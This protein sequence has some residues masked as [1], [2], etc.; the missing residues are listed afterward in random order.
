MLSSLL[1]SEANV[2]APISCRKQISISCGSTLS[3]DKSHRVK[4]S[5]EFGIS[6]ICISRIN[7][8]TVLSSSESRTIRQS[9][10]FSNSRNTSIMAGCWG[11]GLYGLDF[12]FTP[13]PCV[14]GGAAG[15][16]GSAIVHVYRN[17][18]ITE[19]ES[20]QRVFA[21][22]EYFPQM[23]SANMPVKTSVGNAIT[24]YEFRAGLGERVIGIIVDKYYLHAYEELHRFMSAGFV[25]DS[26]KLVDLQKNYANP[27]LAPLAQQ[28]SVMAD[29]VVK[30]I[31][32]SLIKRNENRQFEGFDYI[33][34]ENEV[35]F[36]LRVIE[37]CRNRF[38]FV[39]GISTLNPT[40]AFTLENLATCRDDMT[41]RTHDPPPIDPVF[42]LS[43]TLLYDSNSTRVNFLR[44]Y[45]N[46]CMDGN[47]CLN[48]TN[49]TV[50]E[51]NI[52]RALRDPNIL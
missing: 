7:N 23:Y 49:L 18:A 19:E 16:E 6:L 42:K 14:V 4:Y 31:D 17:G 52:L 29:I 36:S 10:F 38:A 46:L 24:S 3:L 22:I 13:F 5:T 11:S 25:N 40:I 47:F 28:L 44:E 48:D 30:E 34:H 37:R 43:Q 33:K 8:K 45:A 12:M 1:N 26:C 27:T 32:E 20:V 35:T 39:Y 51:V 9:I 41:V 2:F 15:V 50:S 21:L